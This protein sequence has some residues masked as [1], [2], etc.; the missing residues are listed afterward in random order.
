MP[1]DPDDPATPGTPKRAS[2]ATKNGAA[3]TTPAN[4]RASVQAG[5]TPKSAPAAAGHGSRKKPE[6]SLLADFLLGRPSTARNGQRSASKQRRKSVALDAAG[7]REE[8]RQEM[9]A[10]AVRRLQQ[11]GGVHA[12]VKAWQKTNAAA[13]KAEGGGIPHAED[14]ASEPTEVGAHIDDKSVTEEDRVRIKFR[15]KPKKPRAE[16]AESAGSKGVE[17]GGDEQE[18]DAAGEEP[19]IVTAEPAQVAEPK[20]RPKKRIVSDSNWMKRNKGKEKAKA[21]GS[22]TPIPKDFLQR[23]AQNPKVQDKIKDWAKRVEIPDPPPMESPKPARKLKPEDPRVMQYH[24]KSGETVTVEEDNSSVAGLTQRA[25]LR[26][27][28][29]A[30]DGIRVKPRSDPLADDGIRV[31]PIKVRK[32]KADADDGIRILPVRNKEPPDDDGIRVTPTMSSSS[33][34]DDGIRVTP[35]VSSSSLPDDGIR[36]TPTVS[37]ALPDDSTRV[38]PMKSD[39]PDDGIRIRPGRRTSVD[40]STAR[41]PSASSRR[42]SIE[43]STRMP[44]TRRDRSPADMIEVIEESETEIAT[45]TRRQ[46][47]VQRKA[48]PNR[49]LSPKTRSDKVVKLPPSEVETS[50]FTEREGDS[51][52]GSVIPPT[53]AGG[54]SLA[55]IPVGY[56]AFSVLDLPST[57]NGPKK[58]KAQRNPS[59]KGVPNVLRKVMTG[60]KEIIQEKV[61]PPKPANQPPSI[62]K[63]LNNTVDPFVDPAEKK[64]PVEENKPDPQR[65]S[66]SQPRQKEVFD[67]PRKRSI[68]QPRPKEVV[69]E[70]KRRS[71][72]QPRQ[73]ASE[74]P[75]KRSV[76]HARQE[77]P[78]AEPQKRSTSQAR[79]SEPI[80]LA[81]A[82]PVIETK[83]DTTSKQ[84]DSD[85]TPKKSKA[86]G[87][88]SG[89]LKR[90]RATRSASS[91]I[92][93]NGKKPFRE[94][95]KEAFRGE[96]GGHKLPPMVYP[97]CETDY[98]STLDPEDDESEFTEVRENRR[99]SSGSSG[100]SHSPDPLSTVDSTLSSDYT[101]P[102]PSRRRPPTKGNHALSTIVSEEASTVISDTISDISHTTITQETAFTKS[103]EL[104]RRKSSKSSLKR[105]LT[106]HSDLVSVLS[107]PGDA[108]APN[109]S[110]SIKSSHSLHRKP[111]KAS[112][113]RIDELLDEF[114]DDEHFY[115]REL[116]TLVDGVVPVL[117]R[118]VMSS[119]SA[120]AAAGF[121]R[122]GPGKKEDAMGKAVV[123]MGVTLE[124]LRN[125]HRSVPLSDIRHLLTW[126]E[127][128]AVVYDDYLDVW[129]LG[130]QDL[131]VNLAPA[132]H[133][134]DG[135]SLVGAL[136]RNENGD[137]LGEHGERVD[138]AY[139]LKRPLIRIKWITKFLKAA[140]MV[141]ETREADD[142]LARYESLQ[143]KARQRHREELARMT[144]EDANNTDTTRARDLRNL[145]PLDGVMIDPSRQ[146]AAKDSFEMD[147]DHSSGQRLECQVELIHRD[148][149]DYPADKGDILVRQIG[150]GSQSWL[151]FPPIPRE[152]ASARR[153]ES[154]QVLIVMVRGAHNRQEWFELIKLSTDSDDQILDWLD[155]LGS[156]PLPPLTRPVPVGDELPSTP[157]R[158]DAIDIPVGE[159]RFGGSDSASSTPER[160]K[161]PTPSRYRTVQSPDAPRTPSSPTG[162]FSLSSPDR[163]PTRDSYAKL[164]SPAHPLPTTPEGRG[165]P[166]WDNTHRDPAKSARTPP[167][168]TPFREDGAPPPPIH[169]TLSP[170]GPSQLSAPVDT[171]LARVKRRGSSPLKHE[172]HPSDVSSDSSSATSESSSDSSESSSDELDEDEVPDT[173]PG[174]SIRKP[175][176]ASAESVVSESSITPSHSASQVGARNQARVDLERPS[177]RFVAS[178]SY[179]STRK[180]VWKDIQA[181]QLSIVIYPGSLEVHRLSSHNG[182]AF[183]LQS[184]GTSE[185]DN[186]DKDAGGI[187][188]LVGLILTPVVMIRRSTALDLEIRSPESPE[189]RLKSGSAMFRLRA[190]SQAEAKELYDAVHKSRLNNA[191]YIQLSEEARVR[192]FGT[193]QNAPA[194]GSADGDSSS[195]RRSFFGR[196]NSYRASTRAPSLSLHSGS[197][198]ISATSFLRRLTGGGN[199]SFNIDESSVDK[200]SRPG[201]IAGAGGGSL[202]SSSG[203]STGG[204]LSTP[205]RSVSISLSGSGSGASQSR[206]SNGLSKPFSPDSPLEIRCHLNVHNNRWADKG[207]CILHISQPP[208][209]VRQ[210][211]RLN[212]G[213]EKRI[214]VTHMTKK[215]G[216]KA[217]I[218]LDAVLGSKCFSTLGARG[219]M[220]SVWE[221]LRDEDGNVGVAPAQGALAGRVTKWCFQCKNVQ[222]ARVIM[223]LVTSEVPGLM[224]N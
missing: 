195:R 99:H 35:T 119:D 91:P 56:S 218:L 152:R 200:Q 63:W 68:S 23:T 42:T 141:M 154:N 166:T 83:E 222:Q 75:R 58:P 163:T 133:F 134:D 157:T 90:R 121:P 201:S 102:H 50:V 187:V 37:S 94:A 130:F 69:E 129:R 192:S 220:C 186:R 40:E 51:D 20:E 24:T 190:P 125:L 120:K 52:D 128:V 41:S 217:T 155:I 67:E 79:R 213:M 10:A 64:Q 15:K 205:P 8:L 136:P 191:R 29:L 48:P 3:P 112:R 209:G 170:K 34:P 97:S 167:N 62:E 123:N 221:N 6:P 160:A 197:T 148:K 113:G 126:L 135:D 95:L 172:Y 101:D 70:P 159:R 39:L 161:T 60:A 224:G 177:Q 210:E 16:R 203:S 87:T 114:S 162:G 59:F 38:R 106:K 49:S 116:K 165:S 13:M 28:P 78:V 33:L 14:I 198:S 142:L 85:A 22:P 183:Q 71:V 158:S 182:P 76:S 117:L 81:P 110:R 144:D 206:W 214:I 176:P 1:P 96:S 44:S 124:R 31:R 5:G 171:G 137:V 92:K 27:D 7:V 199:A 43:R 72:S 32:P 208:P 196:K 140:V 26:S 12:R 173:I 55:D 11:P 74:E 107:L 82:L 151:L 181:G 25:K 118:D 169:R 47:S 73:H 86:V 132:G 207:D 139:L 127:T 88:P 164:S 19:D 194:D 145:A 122:A 108:H 80:K 104:S 84:S 149:P 100:R 9:K 168:S 180:G 98:E 57:R 30:D 77:E 4:R 131:I 93:P 212:H 143:E 189:S 2:A 178:V 105:R 115:G 174:Y 146:V 153:G 21:E 103:T 61:E 156:Y 18:D 150:N 138:V 211:L 65:R 89:G 193:Q 185:V 111:S 223:G 147:L 219:I 202:E 17:G 54:K 204:G 179:W 66:V 175:E 188:P 46:A 45:P 184:G 216:D 109:R 215:T 36:V 53:I